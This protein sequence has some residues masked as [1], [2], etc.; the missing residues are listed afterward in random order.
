MTKVARSWSRASMAT[1][2]LAAIALSDPT[3]AKAQDRGG[4]GPHDHLAQKLTT[5]SRSGLARE[6]VATRG[7]AASVRVLR[8]AEGSNAALPAA[9][10][11]FERLPALTTRRVLTT[12]ST[13]TGAGEQGDS[14]NVNGERS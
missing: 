9:L 8:A 12:H 14:E 3:F 1:L 2:M 5:D 4:F 7:T 13:I 10:D 11:E 6:A